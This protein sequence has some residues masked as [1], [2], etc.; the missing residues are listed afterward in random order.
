MILKSESTAVI[1][2]GNKRQKHPGIYTPGFTTFWLHYPKR[3]GKD[4]AYKAWTK[5][6]CEGSTAEILAAIERQR[7]WLMRADY[8]SG[9][10][11][12]E[13]CPNPSTWLNQGRWQDEPPDLVD[14]EAT[15]KTVGN[16]AAGRAFLK[17]S[18]IERSTSDTTATE[19]PQ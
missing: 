10:Q 17:R 11:P 4:E 12:G 14:V 18:Q 2:N 13:L 15:G 16:M 19:V 1:N 7:Q 3:V 8:R 9:K 6:S 5:R